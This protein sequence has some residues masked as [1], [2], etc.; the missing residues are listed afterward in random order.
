MSVSVWFRPFKL[1]H[2]HRFDF[3]CFHIFSNFKSNI[4]RLQGEVDLLMSLSRFKMI[5]F[6]VV[7][8]DEQ[9]LFF[10]ICAMAIYG[11]VRRVYRSS[12]Q[13]YRIQAINDS[14]HKIRQFI[15]DYVDYDC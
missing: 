11:Q 12:R 5:F 2:F 13:L 8:I 10:A 6:F 4:N 7:V 14:D 1:T 9:N 3:A 15:L